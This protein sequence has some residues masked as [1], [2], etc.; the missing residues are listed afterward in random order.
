MIED[1]TGVSAKNLTPLVAAKAVGSEGSGKVVLTDESC[2]PPLESTIK[3][4]LT[5]S[6]C[7]DT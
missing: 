2:S 6:D 4:L 3:L 5:D 1:T 7:E